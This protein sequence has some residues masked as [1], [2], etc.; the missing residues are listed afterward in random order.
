M[1]LNVESLREV[2][3]L[4]LENMIPKHQNTN[5]VGITRVYET[6]KKVRLIV[7]GKYKQQ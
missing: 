4:R 3:T 5:S 6:V 7:S 2:Y 1:Q